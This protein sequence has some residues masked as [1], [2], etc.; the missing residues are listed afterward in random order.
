MYIR[1]RLSGV[2]LGT[3]RSG[4]FLGSFLAF[5][6]LPLGCGGE[7]GAG[8]QTD[9]PPAASAA[10]QSEL[11]DWELENGIGPITADVQLDAIDPALVARGEEIFTLKCSACHKLDERYVAPPLR[12]VTERRTPAFM[13]NMML[14][15]F[16]MT[17]K[18]PTVRELLAEYY[19]PMT[20]QGLTE[21]DARAV[22]DY[23]RQAQAD[24]P[25]SG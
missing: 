5:L 3:A 7:Q 24:G 14:N 4:V 11:S 12:D 1:K 2:R 15:S 25:A 6:L 18:H 10:A 16:E 8:D 17:Q 20:D 19:T 22:L 23:L 9:A 21:E 13:L